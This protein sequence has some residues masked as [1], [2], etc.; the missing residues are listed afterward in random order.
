VNNS[1]NGAERDSEARHARNDHAKYARPMF[2][3]A[4]G[5]DEFQDSQNDQ[6]RKQSKPKQAEEESDEW[7]WW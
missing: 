4:P 5:D 1:E 6:Y 3:Q 7:R 2:F